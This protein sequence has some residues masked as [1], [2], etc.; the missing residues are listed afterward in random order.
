M[1]K[2]RK[3]DLKILQIS[4]TL[5]LYGLF[6][7]LP[8]MFMGY[9]SFMTPTDAGS[10]DFGFTLVNYK[11]NLT[12]GFFWKTLLKTLQMG[13]ITTLA[14]IIIGYPV[15]Y[16]LAR[17]TSKIKGLLFMIIISPLLIGVETRCYGWMILL[18][19]K[20]L[21]ND[22]LLKLGIISKSIHLMYNSIGVTLALIQVFVPFMILSLIS[23]IQSINP[24]LQT[25][26]RSLGASKVSTFF[27]ITLPLS[28]PGIMSGSILVF[29]LSISA[30]TIP[31]LLGGFKVL[32]APLLIIQTILEAFNWPL[33]SAMAVM[34]F[35]LTFLVIVLF[36]GLMNRAMKGLK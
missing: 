7:I 10:Y 26:A 22:S 18:A 23:N 19:D 5:L 25:T 33:G 36:I 35:M 21:I 11:T 17:T 1:G 9:I 34:M 27:K 8:Y 16:H 28:L 4:P 12:D 30:Y 29:V 15:A 24:E 13:V 32:T 14:C 31:V 3:I 20:G 2:Y 6:F